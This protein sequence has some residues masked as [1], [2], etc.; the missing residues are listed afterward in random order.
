MKGIRGRTYRKNSTIH[1]AYRNGLVT[2]SECG[3]QLGRIYDGDREVDCWACL[4]SPKHQVPEF[5]KT[6]LG[7]NPWPTLGQER[8]Q[9][10][11]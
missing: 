6:Y 11:S 9:E 5:G 4:T 2:L 3:V 1:Y 8:E 7:H 10:E